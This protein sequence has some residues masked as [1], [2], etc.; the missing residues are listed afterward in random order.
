MRMR[1]DPQGLRP[2]RTPEAM[3]GVH[4]ANRLGGRRSTAG[5]PG[6]R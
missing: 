5:S 6:G 4:E 2:P 1:S 3:T